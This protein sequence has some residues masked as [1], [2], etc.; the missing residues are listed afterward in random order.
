MKVDLRNNMLDE[1][2]Q[3]QKISKKKQGLFNSLFGGGK[4]VK[5]LEGNSQMVKNL[6]ASPH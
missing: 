6:E 1:N 2:Q 3:K 4:S 5:K